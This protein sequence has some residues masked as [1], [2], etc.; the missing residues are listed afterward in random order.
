MIESSTTSTSV[1]A[2]DKSF[3]PLREDNEP[4]EAR[5]ADRLAYLKTSW[6]SQDDLV[7]PY[8]RQV[9][10]NVRMLAG[11]QNS[12]YH[13][14][15]NR[16]IDISE[17]WSSDERTW[18]QQPVFNRLLPWFII[19]HARATENLPI[20]TFVPGPDRI[21]AELAEI[22]DIAQKMLWR[23]LGMVDNHDRMAM[24]MI[25]AG[26]GHMMS[27]IDP[28]KG[29]LKPW[30]GDAEL[31][32]TDQYDSPILD[33]YGEPMKQQ[34]SDVPF[35]QE[36]NPLAKLRALDET[37]E[38]T[39]LVP[40]GEPHAEPE[41]Q[42]CVDVLSPMQVRGEWGPSA[43]HKKRWHSYKSFVT[44][45][46]IFELTGQYV[47]P[48]VK[49][50]G[51]AD[52][53]ELERILFGTGF[54]GATSG[55]PMKQTA[56]ANTDGYCELTTRYEIPSPRPGMENGRMMLATK[57]TLL[58][59]GP[60]PGNFKHC[61]PIRTWEFVRLPG[62]FGGTTPQ[63]AMNP[64]QRQYN[65]IAGSVSQHVHLLTNPKTLIDGRTGIEEG[66]WTNA[67]GE[68]HIITMPNGVSN[69]V[70][71]L[72]APSLGNDTYKLMEILL[73]ELT[74]IGNLNGTSGAPPE[75]SDPSGE[76][77]KELRF[78]TDRF[79]GPTLRRAPEEYARLIEDWQVLLP[80]IWDEE[81]TIQYAGEDNIAR[82]IVVLPQMFEEGNINIIPDVESMLPEGRGERQTRVYKMYMDGLLGIPGEP[83]TLKKFYEL[84]H[85][86]HMS[87]VTK[88]GGV[89]RTTAEQ[90]NGQ[91]LQGTDPREIPVYEWYDHD[92]HLTVLEDFMKSPE[93]KKQDPQIQSGYVFHRKAHQ[94]AQA[95]AAMVG[96][97]TQQAMNP[98]PMLG[99]GSSPSGA[100]APPN[101]SVQPPLPTA[102]SGGVPG[103]NL[104]TLP[105]GSGEMEI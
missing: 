15:L 53:G 31:E 19:T 60:R 2:R 10:E 63:E 86:P 58:Y 65:E 80:M 87:R 25:T 35:D 75:G 18:R 6:D 100:G 44:P 105:M 69:P 91:L 34:A 66:N 21:D 55:D 5:D 104:P 96:F 40:H 7:R 61:S 22:M 67:P 101:T 45:E 74:D 89:D 71:Y 103:G 79:L 32:V 94:M 92:V 3:I 51:V 4:D 27:R 42:L 46:E 17:W 26:R 93:F 64:I 33:Q 52:F 95:Q 70:Q 97:Q 43:W 38:Q 59:D 1:T 29:K 68:T 78:N 24:W 88:V 11:Q 9:E 56:G 50:G 30:I 73:R 102:P 8:N 14:I 13:P 28:N 36:G 90:E 41:G 48:D 12:V 84:M 77:I 54:Y 23:E 83:A 39:E 16:W 99:A 62:R 37:G 98:Q 20:L 47:E 49:T 82:T 81:R 57:K 72:Q 76:L 85:M